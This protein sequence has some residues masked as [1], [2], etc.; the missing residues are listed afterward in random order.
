MGKKAILMSK[1][2]FSGKPKL[3]FNLTS[4]VYLGRIGNTQHIVVHFFGFLWSTWKVVF[5]CY[6]LAFC[7]TVIEIEVY[8]MWGG[9]V[10]ISNSR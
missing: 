6:F 1:R 9:V 3:T 2:G 10:K 5:G 4:G 7:M 8:W